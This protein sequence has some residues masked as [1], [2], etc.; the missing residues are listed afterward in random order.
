ML[1][2]II[3][4]SLVALIPLALIAYIDFGGIR[5]ALKDRQA[6]LARLVCAM[7]TDCPAGFVCQDGRC[8]P[9]TR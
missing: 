7:D 4:A 1:I 2:A 5:K 3:T 9:A 8:I 6:R